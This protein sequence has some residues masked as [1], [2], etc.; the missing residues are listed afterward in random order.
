LTE[1][2]RDVAIAMAVVFVVVVLI[3]L[4]RLRQ[5][6]REQGPAQPRWRLILVAIRL[7]WCSG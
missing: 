5:F 3:C 1:I 4:P 2:V 6:T 7:T